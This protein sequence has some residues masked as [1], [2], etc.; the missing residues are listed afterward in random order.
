MRQHWGAMMR[1]VLFQWGQIR[2]HAYPVMLYFGLV[3]GV[4]GGTYAGTLKGLDQ[5]RVYLAMMLLILPAL[6]GARLLFVASHWPLFRREPARIW[7]RADGGAALYG[8]LLASFLL[9]LPLL[10]VLE[11]SVGAFWD[12]ATVTLLIGMVFTKVGC[13][14]NGCCSGRPTEGPVA[15]YLPNYEGIWCRRYPA[16][17]LEAA[18]AA[19]L[20]LG[21]VLV[22]NRLPFD[23]AVF[24]S[25]LAGYGVGRWGLELTR[26]TID[27]VGPVALNQALSAGFVAVSLMTFLL[28]WLC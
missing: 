5:T 14:L 21:A 9:S 11:V 1:R 13:L 12:A 10:R 4:I 28:I 2:I 24:L 18:F 27:R 6:V 20:L 17:L 7:R 3:F 15:L 8:G 26:E 19:L 16:Q 22:W 25:A 23:G